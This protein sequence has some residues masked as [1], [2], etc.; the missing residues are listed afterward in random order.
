MISFAQ[1]GGA[2]QIGSE[3]FAAVRRDGVDAATATHCT[4]ADG[5]FAQGRRRRV[6]CSSYFGIGLYL[7][8][9]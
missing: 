3:S 2:L 5:S 9:L 8:N 4:G 6:P 1:L 7:T